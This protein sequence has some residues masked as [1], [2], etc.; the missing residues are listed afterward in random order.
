VNRQIGVEESKYWVTGDP[1]FTGREG[2]TLP[3]YEFW[4]PLHISGTVGTRNVKFG[5][6]I[7]HHIY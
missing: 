5:M 3:T 1:P 6:Q 7:Y 4:D 2:V